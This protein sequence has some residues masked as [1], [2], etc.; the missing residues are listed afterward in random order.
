MPLPASDMISMD[1]EE[2]FKFRRPDPAVSNLKNILGGQKQ[3]KLLNRKKV[4]RNFLN[5]GLKTF[6]SASQQNWEES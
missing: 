5:S 6:K 2:D 1:I 3:L 4:L